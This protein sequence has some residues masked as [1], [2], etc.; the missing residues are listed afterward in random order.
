MPYEVT[1]Y[2]PGLVILDRVYG[3]ATMQ[4][5]VETS[6]LLAEMLKR[7]EPLPYIHL[8]VDVSDLETLPVELNLSRITDA[9]QHMSSPT[10]G[11]TLMV[12]TNPFARFLATVATQVMRQRFR[13]FTSID[14]ALSF[15]GGQDHH[16]RER[17]PSGLTDTQP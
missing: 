11:W 17:L 9:M 5:V 10:L 13:S 4:D 15:L 14:E 8:I 6:Q 1:W 2:L 7:D 16:V 3:K 12:T